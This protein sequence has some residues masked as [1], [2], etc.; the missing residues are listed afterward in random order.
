MASGSISTSG[1]S[2][3]DVVIFLLVTLVIAVFVAGY[4]QKSATADIPRQ[5]ER[6][7]TTKKSTN[8][9]TRIISVRAKALQKELALKL[10]S[11]VTL[12]TEGILFRANNSTTT[13]TD[14]PAST[15]DFVPQ[16]LDTLRLLLE[17]AD[18]FLLAEAQEGQSGEAT[19]RRVLASLEREKL[20]RKDAT[21]DQ[22]HGGQDG[23]TVAAHKILFHSTS[24]GKQAIVRHLKPRLHIDHDLGV[25]THLRAFLP[26]LLHVA[27]TPETSPTP[28]PE[29][30]GHVRSLSCLG[31][32]L[33][34]LPPPPAPPLRPPV[35]LS[36][37]EREKA[38]QGQPRG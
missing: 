33:T 34:L 8:V 20:V 27:S 6:E 36:P 22:E 3:S 1:Q 2:E 16:A 28:L 10:G 19:Q 26:R 12:A 9:P 35:S 32:L 37:L 38:G 30:P 23:G 18:V 21:R 5:R 13:S 25:L 11:P 7:I 24:I 15:Y 14:T 17:F 4:L 31:S 29:T